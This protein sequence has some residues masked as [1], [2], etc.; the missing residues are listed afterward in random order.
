[1]DLISRQAV[2]ALPKDRIRNMKGEIVEETID[3]ADIKALPPAQQWIPA[4]ETLPEAGTSYL[5][6]RNGRVE[7]AYYE[8]KNLWR[9]LQGLTA[10]KTDV[11]TAWCELPLPYKGGTRCR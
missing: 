2:L 7:I 5:I 1:M 4:E 3:V 8:G 6:T 11:V 9:G 10:F